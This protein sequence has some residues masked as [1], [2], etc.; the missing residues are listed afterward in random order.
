MILKILSRFEPIK[1]PNE[2]L[3]KKSNKN[4]SNSPENESKHSHPC[5]QKLSLI[6]HQENL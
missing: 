6:I 5:P 3:P 1:H 4:P 2:F